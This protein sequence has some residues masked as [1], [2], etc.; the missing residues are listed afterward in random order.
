[1]QRILLPIR[2]N[3][4]EA[5]CNMVDDADSP[6]TMEELN[7]ALERGRIDTA[8]GADLITYKKASELASS[9]AILFTLVEKRV[10]VH[11]LAWTRNCTTNREARGTFQGKTT[12]FIP[13][14]NGTPQGGIL[15][16]YLFN[17]L[18]ENLDT[19]NLPNGVEIF[20]YADDICIICPNK[21]YARNASQKALDMIQTKCNDLG[22]K[23]NTNKPKAMAIKH[24][25][26]PQNFTLRGEAIEWVNQFMYFKVIISKML[27][28]ANE[29][30]YLR[31]K[32][33]VRL[34]AMRRMS[35]LKQGVSNNLLRLFYLQAI[36]SHI[37]Y[38]APTLT[39]M[40]D[41]LKEPLEVV[42][43]NAMRLIC[44][45][46]M[47]TRLCLLR[48][49]TNLISLSTR[50]DIR[51]SSL[52]FKSIIADRTSPLNNKLKRLLPLAEE[53][54]SS[55]SHAKKLLDTLRRIQMQNEAHRTYGQQKHEGYSTPA[56]WA[57]DPINYN[58]PSY[59]QL[60]KPSQVVS[61]SGYRENWR[62]SN[63][64]STLQTELVAIGKA[65]ENSSNLQHG[66]T[67]I[68]TDSR[69]AILAL[70]NKE[71]T[72][73]VYLI[74]AIH[75]NNNRQ[76]TLNWIPSHTDI[77]GND[78]ADHLAK[79]ALMCQT[80][81]IT[82]QPSLK[83]IQ[84]QMAAYCNIQRT[85]EV[86]KTPRQD[87]VIICRLRLGYLCCWQIILDND[88]DPATQHRPI[89]PCKYC[90]LGTEEPLQHYL[91]HC[92]E[93]SLLRQDLNPNNPET[94]TA[95]VK[96]IIANVDTLSAFLCS[97]PPPR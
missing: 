89:R 40:T 48:A 43:N 28:P 55:N 17:I 46:L 70:K 77:A 56:P 18:M 82:V 61:P 95:I 59:Q 76:V 60:A 54:D 39:T 11:L 38:V 9:P 15:S 31:E 10:K 57:Q 21:A 85:S 1:M 75:K 74:T 86:R 42:Q 66:N 96:H 36:R 71:P 80:I 51:N 49:E 34:S 30:T 90:N 32:T 13:L 97:Y 84:N 25:Q 26:N 7:T 45:T 79:S 81:S 69:G 12:D 3:I 22:L 62:L 41:T 4:I 63:H 58:L 64:A 27:S 16:S 65:L 37:D 35:S 94:A 72:E 20:I 73:N 67:T 2:N 88:A 87:A 33:K 53:I 19:L 93:T 14:E 47:W 23:I 8:P 52:I 78:K 6:Y 29:V 24:P 91:Q 83:T 68:H 50:I 5:A 92:Q 44:G